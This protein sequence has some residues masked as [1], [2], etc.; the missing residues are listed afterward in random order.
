MVV[1]HRRELR[2]EERASRG[3]FKS[4]LKIKISKSKVQ[5]Q[6]KKSGLILSE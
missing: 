5:N 2:E 1:H 3:S 6:K 4:N